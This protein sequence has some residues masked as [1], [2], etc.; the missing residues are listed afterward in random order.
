MS[1]MAW[2]AVAASGVLGVV[3]GDRLIE[4]AVFVSACLLALAGILA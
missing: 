1:G 2:T 4:A 3:A